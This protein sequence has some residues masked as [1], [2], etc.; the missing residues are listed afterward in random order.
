MELTGQSIIG[1]QRGA[2]TGKVLNG[3]NPSTGEVLTPA[4]Y[5]AS[6]DEVDES[7]R[8]AAESFMR[9]SALAGKK[10]AAFLR[11]IAENLEQLGETLVE[12]AVLESG[13]P[14]ARIRSER[15]RT[16]FQLRFFAEMVDNGSWADARIDRADPARLPN[17]KPDVRSMLRPL[18]PVVVFCA[19]N[20]PL[21]F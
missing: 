15:G 14:A 21:A 3:L 19:S 6:E 16:C 9:F 17:P 7:V 5:S 4:F 18:G 13:L 2:K 12:R 1:Y 11:G 8:L 10:R 20:F